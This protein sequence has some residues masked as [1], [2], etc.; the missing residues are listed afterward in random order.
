V[1]GAKKP[2]PGGGVVIIPG[3]FEGGSRGTD[4]SENYVGRSFGVFGLCPK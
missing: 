4:L 3:C 1:N 2:W